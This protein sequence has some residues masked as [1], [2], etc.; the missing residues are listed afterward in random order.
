GEAC[1][2]NSEAASHTSDEHRVWPERAPRESC[3]GSSSPTSRK[4]QRSRAA[5][6]SPQPIA[7]DDLGAP[8][9]AQTPRSG[10]IRPQPAGSRLDEFFLGRRPDELRL[11]SGFLLGRF[12]LVE[13]ERRAGVDRRWIGG[14]GDANPR[15]RARR[16]SPLETW[17]GGVRLYFDRSLG[18]HFRVAARVSAPIRAPA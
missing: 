5:S 18:T 9:Q 2:Y 3:C 14:R 7:A 13:T 16:R 4:T 12:G 17:A 10:S 15:W 1:D 6:R 11:V 8:P